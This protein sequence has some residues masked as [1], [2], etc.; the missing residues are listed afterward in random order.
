M[1]ADKVGMP[2]YE[3]ASYPTD[4]DL[5]WALFFSKEFDGPPIRDFQLE[6]TPNCNERRMS[7]D[8]DAEQL[9]FVNKV[10]LDSYRN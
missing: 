9:K 8:K 5:G 4:T 2:S 7:P 1:S 3:R 6:K 10:G